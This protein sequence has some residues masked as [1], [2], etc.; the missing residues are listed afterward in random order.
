[1]RVKELDIAPGRT[2]KIILKKYRLTRILESWVE[3]NTTSDKAWAALVDFA[4]WP[5]WN[6]FIPEVEGKLKVDN[7]MR[8]TVRSPG[9]KEMN[10]K[11]TVLAIEEGKKLVWGGGAWYIGY[12]GVHEFIIED[13]AD[14]RIRFKQIEKFQGPIVLFMNKMINK[15]A[16]GYGNMNEEFK[17][18]LESN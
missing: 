12:K 14:N 15:T 13:I 2:G 9:L 4:Y 10:F 6:S 18:Y 1:M 17:S 7:E 5:S 11:P 3:I 8:I 16:V